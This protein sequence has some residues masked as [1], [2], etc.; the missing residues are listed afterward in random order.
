MK[1]LIFPFAAVLALAHP[2]FGEA[3]AYQA[4]DELAERKGMRSLRDIYLIRGTH[5]APQPPAWEVYQARRNAR[6]LRVTTIASSGK[7]TRGQAPVRAMGLPPDALPIN[8]TVLNLD[9]HAAWNIAKRHARREGF[10][11]DSADYELKTH[12]LARAPAW[13]LHLYNEKRGMLGII[14]LSGATGEVLNRLKLYTFQ[15]GES[16][17]LVRESWGRRAGRSIG[18]WFSNS[19]EAAGHDL[20]NAAGTTEEILLNRRTRHFSEDAR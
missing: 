4:L 10:D 15:Q 7:V 5:G 18:R 17:V 19:G 1:A 14:T 13:T 11:F 9:T 3:S 8:L 6:S 12:L 2:L 20:L 16:V